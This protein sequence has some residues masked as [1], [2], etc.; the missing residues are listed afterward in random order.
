MGKEKFITAAL[1]AVYLQDDFT[2]K[3]SLIDQTKVFLLE[4]GRVAR[5]NPSGLHVF[6]NLAGAAFTARVENKCYFPQ[7]VAINVPTLDPR[8]P[9]VSVT[10]KP[11]YLYPFPVGSTLVRGQ[12]IDSTNG[13]VAGA[14]VSAVGKP[15]NNLTDAKGR[16]V[17][18]FDP[19]A[20]EEITRKNGRR[21]LTLGGS[22]TIR[23]TVTHPTFK[24]K[25]LDIGDVL[26]SSTNLLAVPIT[27]DPI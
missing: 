5:E 4:N 24:N 13:P 16:F 8:L 20:E 21:L 11:N 9:L 3:G 7:E 15:G 19:L 1:F 12:V 25:T 22:T 17:L 26:E 27:L 18:Y 10:M 23:L 2:K 6:L 14:T